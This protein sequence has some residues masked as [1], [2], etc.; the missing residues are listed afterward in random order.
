[1]G[2]SRE[3]SRNKVISETI[4]DN[5]V[6]F[7]TK[8]IVYECLDCL[9]NNVPTQFRKEITFGNI[10]GITYGNNNVSKW[11]FDHPQFDIVSDTIQRYT[12]DSV[13]SIIVAMFTAEF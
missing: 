7:S 9:T 2:N 5:E 3:R 1:M 13:G 4:T 10:T 6:L 8:V 11:S 12:K